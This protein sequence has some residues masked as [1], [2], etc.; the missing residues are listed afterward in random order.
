M[1]WQDGAPTEPARAA[2]VAAMQLTGCDQAE[3]EHLLIAMLSDEESALG[4]ACKRLRPGLDLGTLKGALVTVARARRPRPFTGTWSDS[5]YS[6]RT[7]QLIQQLQ[8]HPLWREAAGEIQERLLASA[9]LEA[10]KPSAR[11]VF[12]HAGAEAAELAALLRAAKAAEKPRVFDQEGRVDRTAFNSSGQRVLNV[13]EADGRGLGLRRVNT[14]LFLLALLSVENGTLDRALR[15]QLIDPRKVHETVLLD[16]KA[17][18]KKRFEEEFT[19]SRDLMQQAVVQTLERAAE[20]ACEM[21]LPQVGEPELAK[22]LLVANDFFVNN[23]LRVHK[24]DLKELSRYVMQRHSGEVQESEAEE[25]RLPTIREIENRLR[26]AIIGQDHVIDIVMPTIK[27]LRFGYTRPNRPMAVLLFLGNSGTGKTQLAKEIARAVYGS[28]ENLIFL[29]MGQFGTELSKNIFVGAPPGYVG[30]G[31]GLLTNG[32]RDKPESVV[33]FDE[34]EKAHKSVFDV[35]LRFLDEGQIAD[36]A[37]P[38]RDGRRCIIILTSNHALDMLQP[39]IDKQSQIKNLSPADREVARMEIRRAILA[40]GLFRPEFLNRVDDLVLFN[41]FDR[42]AYRKILA[43]QL[44]AEQRRLREEKGITLE[45]DEGL[46]EVLVDQCVAR[47]DEGA[48]VCGKLIS[49]QVVAPLIDF[50]LEEGNEH[51]R[52]VRFLTSTDGKIE[53]RPGDEAEVRA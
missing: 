15:L 7:R 48:R 46:V 26:S 18:G 25:K 5:L 22:A 21:G 49:D 41:N 32:L 2:L 20:M 13:L 52:S 10:A 35:L 16:V 50:V 17:L 23:A 33:L 9:A 3:P 53:I 19:L 44:E 14:P 4:K 30:Y 31:E 39:L 38:V 37:G 28:E 36:P 40:T 29:E 24:V 45:F 43:G 8:G 11:R 34:V 42:D 12:D 1:F 6:P 27:R 51:V 47:S